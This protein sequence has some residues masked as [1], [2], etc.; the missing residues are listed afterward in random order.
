MIKGLVTHR[1]MQFALKFLAKNGFFK[2]FALALTKFFF[3]KLKFFEKFFYNPPKDLAI[4]D[5]QDICKQNLIK[6]EEQPFFSKIYSA[7]F[8]EVSTL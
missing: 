2:I 1:K 3:S 7:H 8:G 6:K 5:P 4:A